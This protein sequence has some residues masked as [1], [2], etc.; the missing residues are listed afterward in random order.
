MLLLL[1]VFSSAIVYTI[2]FRID[3]FEWGS[4]KTDGLFIIVIPVWI[5]PTAYI[6]LI[7]KWIVDKKLVIKSKFENYILFILYTLIGFLVLFDSQLLY[8]ISLMLSGLIIVLV[9]II[10]FSKKHCL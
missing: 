2:S 3:I 1:L 9:I 4:S 6:A 5:V 10:M 8:Y 7:I